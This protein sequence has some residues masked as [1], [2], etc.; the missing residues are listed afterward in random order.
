[1][2]RIKTFIK[3]FNE[4]KNFQYRLYFYVGLMIIFIDM[5]LLKHYWIKDFL[6][7]LLLPIIAY[8]IG[9]IVCVPAWML[10][11][12]NKKVEKLIEKEVMQQK[13]N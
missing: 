5:F 1:M 4:L 13:N 8:I 9:C 2:V 12:L 7:F 6:S 11:D 10:A 3:N